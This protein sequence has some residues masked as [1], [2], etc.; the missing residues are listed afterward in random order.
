M[1]KWRSKVNKWVGKQVSKFFI[2]K[3]LKIQGL[4]Q[5]PW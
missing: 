2:K 3:D 1:N 5:G 4:W